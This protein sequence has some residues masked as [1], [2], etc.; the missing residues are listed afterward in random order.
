MRRLTALVLAASAALALACA[1]AGAPRG[2]LER[3]TPPVITSITPD[4]GTLDAKVKQVE[5]KF[6]EVVSD[7]PSGQSAELDQLFLISPRDG[8]PNVSWH[9][10]R[11]T[12]KPRSGFRANTTYRVTMLPGIADLQGNVMKEGATILFSTG[13][14]F[15]AY[16]IV[17]RVFDWTAQ[18]PAKGAYVEAVLTTDT[19]LVYVTATDS[20]G[21]FDVGP[22]PAG[23]YLVRAL[24]DANNNHAR[25]AKEKWDSTTIAVTTARPNIELDAI[26]RDSAPP[27]IMNITAADSV[28]LRVQ[29][30]KAIS[31]RANLSPALFRLERADSSVV[32]IQSVQFAAAFDRAKTVADSIK[33]AADDSARAARDT[34]RRV[35]P[36]VPPAGAPGGARAAPPPPKPRSPAPEATIILTVAAGNR[37]TPGSYRLSVHDLPNLV[38]R[39]VAPDSVRPRGFTIAPPPKPDST[40]A[41]PA[42]TTRRTPPP[43]TRPPVRRNRH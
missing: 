6:D 29:F 33:R 2:A 24:I 1:S 34:A 22:F 38:G 3:K 35:P 27:A 18:A 9:R 8:S 12:V 5:F 16:G 7:R 11:I 43:A 28:D 40:K 20:L 13:G 4:S 14:A 37:L 36:A 31:P 23:T 41:P 42:D 30:D 21:Q 32:P 26:E 10:S 25:D 39:A 15:P 19:T 17:G